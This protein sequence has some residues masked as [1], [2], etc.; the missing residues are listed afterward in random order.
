MFTNITRLMEIK[1]QKLEKFV[2][3]V[4]RESLCQSTKIAERVANVV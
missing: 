3:D 1:P 4:E 2:L